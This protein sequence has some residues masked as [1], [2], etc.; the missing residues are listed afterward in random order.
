MVETAAAR[1]HF[2]GHAEVVGIAY[3]PAPPLTLQECNS[4]NMARKLL[5]RTPVR[6]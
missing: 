6:Q 4:A 3:H 2:S 1:C 5:L